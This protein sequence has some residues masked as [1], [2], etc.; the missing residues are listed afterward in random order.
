MERPSASCLR[1]RASR[2]HRSCGSM[3]VPSAGVSVSDD[4]VAEK[5]SLRPL[6]VRFAT[7]NV[8]GEFCCCWGNTRRLRIGSV[9]SRRFFGSESESSRRLAG[10]GMSCRLRTSGSDW[11]C[12]SRR[13][14]ISNSAATSLRLGSGC[15]LAEL[16]GNRLR[17][18]PSS[19]P[20]VVLALL[21]EYG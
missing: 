5:L 10:S 7:V 15:L 4:D 19:V 20:L 12:A 3:R 11:A 18:L 16:V 14:R 9:S 13:L 1:M 2:F 8:D 21:G 6:F 17:L